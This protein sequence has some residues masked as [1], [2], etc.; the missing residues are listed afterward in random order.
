MK[1]E[2]L[3]KDIWSERSEKNV[4]N[5][6]AFSDEMRE[7]IYSRIQRKQVNQENDCTSNVKGSV[8]EVTV[9][10]PSNS[11]RLSTGKA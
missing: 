8:L 11:N 2:K 3:F 7:R 1:F 6:P 4:Y 9:T 5:V 10:S